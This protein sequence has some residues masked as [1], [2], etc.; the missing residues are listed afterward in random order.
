MERAAASARTSSVSSVEVTKIL[1]SAGVVAGPLYVLL[2]LFQ[3]LIRPGFDWTRHDLSLLSNGPMGWIQVA[4]FVVTGL[5]VIAGAVGMRRAMRG[6]R[7][8]TWAPLLIGLYGLGLIAAGAFVADPMNGF[9]PG[10]PA[11]PPL[12]PTVHGFLHII[13]GAVGF[14]GLIAACFVFARRHAAAREPGW[15][16]FSVAT[17]VLFLFAFF[18]IAG[19]SQQGG[20]TLVVVTVAFTAAV[21]LAWLWLALT[22]SR[23]IA[24]LPH[25]VK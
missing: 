6:S 18:G 15:A 24:Q 8:G 1:L 5:L 11:G 23:L 13:S 10:T 25:P 9:P 4:N 19:G 3:A 12:Q 17:G 16:A 20:T 22:A 7:G 14:L 2:G 21:I